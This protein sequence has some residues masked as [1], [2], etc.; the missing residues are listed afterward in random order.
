MPDED[1]EIQFEQLG[2]LP[3]ECPFQILA[4]D[5]EYLEGED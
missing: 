3:V 1:E 4:E 2:G 5:L